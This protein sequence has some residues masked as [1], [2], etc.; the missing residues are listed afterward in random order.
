MTKLTT[1]IAAVAV[2]ASLVGCAGNGM[3]Q[4]GPAPPMQADA[5][6]EVT[7]NNWS[8]M[9][10]YIARGGMTVRLGTVTSMRTAS[11]RSPAP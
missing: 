8:D 7:N 2:S 3:V 4:D 10:V 1:W 6:V 5:R 11:L 9:R